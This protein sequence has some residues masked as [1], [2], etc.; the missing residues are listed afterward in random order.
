MR[1]GQLWLL[2]RSFEPVLESCRAHQIAWVPFW[3]L[4]SA[5]AHLPKAG[6]DPTVRRIAAELGVTPG[7]V[8]LAWLLERYAGTLL[9]PGTSSP[10]HLREN[11]AAGEVRLPEA[12]RAMLDGL[13]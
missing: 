3:P 7:Q 1:P 12:A 6:D 4:G 5:F 13:G 10:D 11:L 2:D 9:I 8:A